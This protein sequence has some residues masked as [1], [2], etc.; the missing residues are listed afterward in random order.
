MLG[1]KEAG[2]FPSPMD[3]TAT[4]RLL[5]TLHSPH[6]RIYGPSSQGK[7]EHVKNSVHSPLSIRTVHQPSRSKATG[8]PPLAGMC[9]PQGT[10][11]APAGDVGTV[12]GDLSINE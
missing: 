3:V 12:P 4:G 2:D 10:L 7:L 1:Y 9:L 5:L 6:S 8:A 11:W